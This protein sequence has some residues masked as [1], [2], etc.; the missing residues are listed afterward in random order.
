[1]TQ[2]QQQHEEKT[3]NG[4]KLEPG[5]KGE[6]SSPDDAAAFWDCSDACER[7]TDTTIAD[8]VCRWADDLHP[9]PVP[10]TVT[11]YG[12]NPLTLPSDEKLADELLDQWVEHMD[13]N[14]G[15]I[16]DSTEVTQGMK[17]AALVFVAA[18][19]AEY[20]VWRCKPVTKID[21]RVADYYSESVP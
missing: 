9:A 12:W 17:A 15:P 3:E 6:G 14:F 20:H 10:E 8:A 16:E 21:A 5:L 7:L 19:R 11:V 18:F 4:Q 13:E 2:Q 1:M